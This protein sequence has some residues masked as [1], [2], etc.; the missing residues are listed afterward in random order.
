MDSDGS[1]KA[2]PC[3]LVDHGRVSSIFIHYM[4]AQ[5]GLV[6]VG[7]KEYLCL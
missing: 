1:R 7:L 2:S 3:L 4:D 6:L 5:V